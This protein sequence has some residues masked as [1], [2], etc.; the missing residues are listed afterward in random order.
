MW[1][2]FSGLVGSGVAEMLRQHGHEVVRVGV[3]GGLRRYAPPA[4]PLLGIGSSSVTLG[5]RRP[6]G[7]QSAER[8]RPLDCVL[9][10]QAGRS[11]SARSY[12]SGM[13]GGRTPSRS[14]HA[15]RRRRGP[16]GRP[17]SQPEFTVLI[18]RW[19]TRQ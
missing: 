2:V 4:R 7:E 9:N 19:D 1:S 10:S 13:D 6:V 11:R 17:A 14:D 16:P 8:L 12:P 18:R 3:A 5:R 15:R